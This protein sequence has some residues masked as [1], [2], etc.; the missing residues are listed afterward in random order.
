MDSNLNEANIILSSSTDFVLQL[1]NLAS[2][3]QSTI[4]SDFAI[5]TISV[6]AIFQSYMQINT[7]VE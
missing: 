1:A 6:G 4:F 3:N 5:S 7:G 2:Y